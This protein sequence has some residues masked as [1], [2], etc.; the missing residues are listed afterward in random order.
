MTTKK[1]GNVSVKLNGKPRKIKFTLNAFCEVCEILGT[2]NL[3]EVLDRVGSGDFIAVRAALK[4][5][6]N[7]PELSLE[8][9]GAMDM[10][11]KEVIE[12]IAMA[13]AASLLSEKK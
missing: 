12:A 1:R 6:L 4:A 10:E 13:I 7:D 8:D 5:S 2:N 3:E 9:V 11:L